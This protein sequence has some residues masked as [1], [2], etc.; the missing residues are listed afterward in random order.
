MEMEVDS[1]SVDEKNDFLN[2]QDMAI[3]FIFLSISSKILQQVYD[4]S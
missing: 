2:K 3:R 4:E 1:D